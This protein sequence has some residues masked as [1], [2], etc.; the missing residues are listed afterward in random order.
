MKKTLFITAAT[1][2]GVSSAYAKPMYYIGAGA[3]LGN[4]KLTVE[5]GV[6][7][8]FSSTVLDVELGMKMMNLSKHDINVSLGAFF[9]IND[10]KDRGFL[11]GGFVEETRSTPFNY[12][13]ISRIGKE[14]NHSSA[15]VMLGFGFEEL[16]YKLATPLISG[17]DSKSTSFVR[18]GFGFEKRIADY[19]RAYIE[20]SYD[21]SLDK[22][23][24]ARLETSALK[25]GARYTFGH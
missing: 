16:K 6:K 9:G 5:E 1:L 23:E 22:W 3:G 13:L 14:W 11:L 18:T 12:G 4:N 8:S 7:T 17:K 19:L 25:I 15:Y 20:Y 24:G 2:L 10:A 21:I